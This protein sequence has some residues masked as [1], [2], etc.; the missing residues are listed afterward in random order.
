MNCTEDCT[1]PFV[2]HIDIYL[3]KIISDWIHPVKV[4]LKSFRDIEIYKLKCN[5]RVVALVHIVS[6]INNYHSVNSLSWEF[7]YDYKVVTAWKNLCSSA[8]S[9]FMC[10][11]CVCHVFVMCLSFIQLIET[12]CSLFP[13]GCVSVYLCDDWKQDNLGA[14][15]WSPSIIESK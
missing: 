1:Q 4:L 15:D 8:M 3:S 6:S 11:S 7:S 13:D 2:M 10:L 9:A 5:L 12:L 14:E